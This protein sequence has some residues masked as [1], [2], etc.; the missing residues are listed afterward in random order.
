MEAT[1]RITYRINAAATLACAAILVAGGHVLAP[2]FSVPAPA[3]WGTGAFFAIFGAWVWGISRRRR[4]AWTE[5][6]AAGVLDGAYALA[7][8]A[9]LAAYGAHM[10]LA[11]GVA[12]ALLAVPVAVFAAIELRSALRLRLPE[13][14]SR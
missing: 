8:F 12:V 13:P 7:S 4:L 14:A 9:A 10:T 1:L 3:L 5:A 2:L 11:L 6:L